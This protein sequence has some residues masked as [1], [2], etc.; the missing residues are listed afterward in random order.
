MIKHE[1]LIVRS[2]VEKPIANI[3]DGRRWLT[4]LVNRINMK[5]LA[6]PFV[7]YCEKEGNRGFTGAVIIETSH[8]AMHIWDEEHPALVQLDVYTCSDLP[9]DDVF[10]HFNVL[11]PVELSYKFLDRENGLT[12]KLEGN[13]NVGPSNS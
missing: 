5:I 10:A 8:I 6:G 4:E 7:E 12:L 11:Q 3:E 9:L 2:K 1:H 13:S